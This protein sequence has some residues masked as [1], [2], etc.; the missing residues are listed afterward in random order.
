M[1]E[2]VGYNLV[3]RVC[4]LER[5]V[6]KLEAQINMSTLESQYESFK[7]LNP[8]STFTFD[9]WKNWY[10]EMLRDSLEKIDKEND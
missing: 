3:R 7:V 2:E 10:G 8:E 1:R 6:V 5:R 4:E 9:E